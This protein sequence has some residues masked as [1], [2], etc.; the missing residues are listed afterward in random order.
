MRPDSRRRESPSGTTRRCSVTRHFGSYLEL[1]TRAAQGPRGTFFS[2]YAAVGQRIEGQC[3][4][5]T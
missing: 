1:G 2:V 3:N 5:A 4:M